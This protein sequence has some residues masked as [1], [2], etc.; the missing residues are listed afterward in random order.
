MSAMEIG[1]FQLENLSMMPTRF[2]F[3]DLRVQ[4]AA[5]HPQI[6][7]LL[8]KSVAVKADEAEAHLSKSLP[9]KNQPVVLI[10]ESGERSEALA[11]RLETAG[12]TNVYVVTGGVAGLLSEL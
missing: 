7:G 5:V 12:Y 2:M 10:D 3:L 8:K 4:T 1:L 6:D 11:R 9:D